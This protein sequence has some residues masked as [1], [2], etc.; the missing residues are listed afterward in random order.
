[1]V[2]DIDDELFVEVYQSW[3]RNVRTLDNEHCMVG[4]I[5]PGSYAHVARARQLLVRV[6]HRITHDDFNIFIESPE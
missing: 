1:M 3:S 6:R 2:V 4:Q 5:D